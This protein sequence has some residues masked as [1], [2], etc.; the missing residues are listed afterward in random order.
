[1]EAPVI[2]ET[3]EQKKEKLAAMQ[4]MAMG[5]NPGFQQGMAMASMTAN[6]HI[7]TDNMMTNSY[8]NSCSIP[9]IIISG[10]AIWNGNCCPR[11]N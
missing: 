3:E 1:M 6:Q 10:N 7:M 5:Y 2:E 9:S 11:F 8:L 4:G